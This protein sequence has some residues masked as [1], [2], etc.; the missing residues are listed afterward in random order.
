MHAS[1]GSVSGGIVSSGINA[2]NITAGTLNIRNGEHYLKMGFG[3]SHPEVSGLNITGS[4]G[5]AMHGNG[6]GDVGS[7]QIQGEAIG[8]TTTF[9]L[10]A[11]PGVSAYNYHIMRFKYGVLVAYENH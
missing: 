9:Y 3:T 1:S 4:G 6:L 8:P 11:A 7:I 5:I 2:G 10:Q